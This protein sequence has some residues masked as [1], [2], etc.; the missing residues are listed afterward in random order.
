MLSSLKIPNRDATLVAFRVELEIDLENT[1]MSRASQDLYLYLTNPNTTLQHHT[2]TENAVI[3]GEECDEDESGNENKTAHKSPLAADQLSD[4][5]LDKT[6]DDTS[7]GGAHSKSSLPWRCDDVLPLEL[8]SVAA[9]ESGQSVEVRDKVRVVAIHDDT[10]AEQH[11][12]NCRHP[13]DAESL[14]DSEV[15]FDLGG[16]ICSFLQVLDILDFGLF[17]LFAPDAGLELGLISCGVGIGLH[18]NRL[19]QKREVE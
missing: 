12:P 7:D 3:R 5:T 9:L 4:G 10:D 19:E 11:R 18:F 2:C 6:A 8:I 16:L 14:L 17:T 15:V 1:R 13:I